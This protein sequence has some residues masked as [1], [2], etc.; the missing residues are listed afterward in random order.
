WKPLLLI[1]V[2]LLPKSLQDGNRCVDGWM[3]HRSQV[4]Q[5]FWGHASKRRLLGSQDPAALIQVLCC[6]ALMA[7]SA[8]DNSYA[9]RLQNAWIKI[10]DDPHNRERV[11]AIESY[12][13]KTIIHRRIHAEIFGDLHLRSRMR[14]ERREGIEP[15]QE[16]REMDQ[17][18]ESLARE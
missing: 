17:A 1:V 14:C 7:G 16:D 13:A 11:T 12:R 15:T 5:A 9:V 8:H 18:Q 6:P 10:I 2:S 4:L 3:A